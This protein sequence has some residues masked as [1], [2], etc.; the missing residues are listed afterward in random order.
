MKML[1]VSNKCDGCGLCTVSNQY[2]ME[3]EDGNAIPVEGVYIK[4]N[5]IDAVLEIVKLCPN[6]AI[7]IV[8]KGNTNKTGKEA[9]TDL[10]Q[11]MKKKCE[12]I[13]LKEIGRKDVKFD[14]NKCNID[15]PWHY[16]P[17]TYSSYGKAK[18][19]AQ[20]VF[21]KKCYCTGFYRPTMRKIFVE[22]KVDV[23]E[24]Y[25]DLESEKGIMV[26][27]NKE[28]EKFLKSI[29][30]EV[31]AVA[32][33]KLPDNWSNCNA[34]PITDECYEWD[35]LRKYEEKSGHFGIISELEKS[36]SCSSYIDW[37]E[38]DEEEEWVG[39]TRFGNDKYK[40]IW[41]ISDFDEAAKE[42]VKDLIFYANYQDDRIEELAV[43]LVN[44][45][46]K[47][48]NDNLDKIIKEKVEDLMKL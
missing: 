19:A 1:E 33:K 38:I 37:M 41:R 42:Y 17:D 22:Y 31:E 2:L 26:K 39:T 5:D 29:S 40:T 9:I 16:F 21:Q 24:K 36:N 13:K 10:V 32:G 25:Y 14:A 27:T 8:D 20:S 48:Y 7:S 15:I 45:M 12:A 4:E 23:L 47:E 28:M 44:S 35:T 6:G 3:N 11:S 34:K 46:F 43:R 30:T 18:S